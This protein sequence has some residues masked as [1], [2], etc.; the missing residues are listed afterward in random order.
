[1]QNSFPVS[2]SFVKK[3]HPNLHSFCLVK[4]KIIPFCW[5]IS[6][7]ICFFGKLP[8]NYLCWKVSQKIHLVEIFLRNLISLQN[9]HKS[10][11]CWKTFTTI[12]FLGN[13]LQKL[14]FVGK[15]SHKFDFCEKLPKIT[16]NK[17]LHKKFLC[18]ILFTKFH[19]KTFGT[20]GEGG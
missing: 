10:L 18:L 20:R 14:D 17:N 3:L 4:K 12:Y 7:K 13:I 8:Q 2:R 16:L 19:L 15:F 5:K 11:L 6:T 1:M 9:F